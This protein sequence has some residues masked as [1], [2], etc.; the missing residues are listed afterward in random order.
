MPKKKSKARTTDQA[1]ENQGAGRPSEYNPEYCAQLITHMRSG[2]SFEGF[3][4]LIEV[5]KQ[6]LYNWTKKHKEFL[7]AKEVGESVALLWWENIGKNCLLLGP[8]EK[9]NSVVW[10]RNMENRFGWS[11]K[12][13]NNGNLILTPHQYLID[14]LEQKKLESEND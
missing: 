6:T 8:N 1:P 12:V 7:D 11:K 14:L 13:E 5:S 9:F 4:G 10:N 3:A 2:G